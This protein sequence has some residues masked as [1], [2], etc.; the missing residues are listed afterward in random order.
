LC[1]EG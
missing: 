1:E